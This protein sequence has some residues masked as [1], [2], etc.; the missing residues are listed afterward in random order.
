MANQLRICIVGMK[1]ETAS[2]PNPEF[3]V[4]VIPRIGETIFIEG[5]GDFLVTAVWH[6]LDPLEGRTAN[7]QINVKALSPGS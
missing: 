2:D 1:K 3:D 5:K 7:T 6:F 4:G